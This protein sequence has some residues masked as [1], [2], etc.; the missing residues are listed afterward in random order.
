MAATSPT[1]AAAVTTSKQSAGQLSWY[2]VIIMAALSLG[3]F[4]I[5]GFVAGLAGSL[6]GPPVSAISVFQADAGVPAA[7]N[8]LE[9]VNNILSTLRERIVSGYV[10]SV[11]AGTGTNAN[12]NVLAKLRAAEEKVIAQESQ[13]QIALS[14]ATDRAATARSRQLSARHWRE[15][16]IRVASSAACYLLLAGLVFLV[17]VRSR[18]PAAWGSVLGCALMLLL[19]FLAAEV[20]TWVAGLFLLLLTVTFFIRDRGKQDA[21]V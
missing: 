20:A 13:A 5:G 21:G 15:T 14:E 12:S 10:S 16:G 2:D 8:N 11:S 3:A 7:T 1:D 4:G 17:A 6:A 19:A 9:T 18:I